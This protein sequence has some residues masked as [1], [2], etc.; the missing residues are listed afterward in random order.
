MQIIPLV[1]SPFQQINVTLEDIN[2]NFD[3]RWNG[4]AACWKLDIFAADESFTFRGLRLSPGVDLLEGLA[5]PELGG[6]YISDTQR[7]HA[8]PDYDGLGDRYQLF[9]MTLVEIAAL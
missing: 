7:F 6:L 9:Y 2:M 5:L 4:T 8:E 1:P 3:I